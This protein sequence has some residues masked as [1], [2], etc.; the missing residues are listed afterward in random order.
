[1]QVL[2]PL[3]DASKYVYWSSQISFKGE[4]SHPPP[5]HSDNPVIR[6]S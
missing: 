6:F 5:F 2:K 1:M 4:K 3:A